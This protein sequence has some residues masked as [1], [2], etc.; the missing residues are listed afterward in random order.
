MESKK[1]MYLL[2]WILY[3]DRPESLILPGKKAFPCDIYNI[4]SGT[5]DVMVNIPW[6]EIMKRL[7][8]AS[9]KPSFNGNVELFS[10]KERPFWTRQID[11]QSGLGSILFLRRTSSFI[12]LRTFSDFTSS[13]QNQN[14]SNDA[15]VISL[16]VV[17]LSLNQSC[18]IWCHFFFS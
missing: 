11:F 16:I 17:C 12:R 13:K 9:F 8:G 18:Q 7:H 4:V 10:R 14:D 5:M 3:S 6:L 1:G 2:Q 15:D